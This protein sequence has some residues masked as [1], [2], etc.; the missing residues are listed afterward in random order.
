MIKPG[1]AYNVFA[2]PAKP[3]LQCSTLQGTNKLYYKWNRDLITDAADIKKIMRDTS[4]QLYSN[5]F[6][7]LR[8]ISEFLKK[9]SL[10][11][12][13]WEEINNPMSIPIRSKATNQL[14]KF[15][16]KDTQSQD[17]YIS[18]FYQLFKEN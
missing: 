8:E 9:Y 10:P 15:S 7:Y 14:S 1:F 5:K 17:N 2:K 3:K 11:K 12:L 16:H 6:E 13:N 4:G 18:K